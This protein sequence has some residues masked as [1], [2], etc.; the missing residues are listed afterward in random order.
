MNL[1][2][3][4]REPGRDPRFATL[5]QLGSLAVLD[6]QGVILAAN[7]RFGNLLGYSPCELAGRSILDFTY[8]KDRE[9]GEDLLRR[10]AAGEIDAYD[11]ERRYLRKDGSHF[12]ALL[13][14]SMLRDLQTNEPQLF[15][16][17]IQDI[18]AKKRA[19]LAL[20][21][22]ETRWSFALES[23]RQG[24]WD[25]RIA[26]RRTFRSATWKAMLG[27]EPHEI[28]DASDAWLA[29]MHPDDLPRVAELDKEQLA[30]RAKDFECEFRMRHKQGH[31][32][33]I[34]DRAKIVERGADGLPTR[35]IGTH[36]DVSAQ[37]AFEKLLRET[38][39]Q[40]RVLADNSSDMIL[41]VNAAGQRLY[42][43]PACRRLLGWEPNEM[44][45]I[46]SHESI[47][48]EDAAAMP[49]GLKGVLE[50][51]DEFALIHRMRRKDG[52]YVWVEAISRALPVGEGEQPERIVIARNIDE[53][54]AAE[55]RLKNSEARYRLLAECSSDLVFQLDSH[56]FCRYVSPAC[57]EILGYEPVELLGIEPLSID[58]PEDADRVDRT[59][60]SLISGGLER[61][62][63]CSRVRRRDGGWLWVDSELRLL[64]D[65]QTGAPSGIL[66]SLR[67]ASRRKE[68]E[69]R[70]KRENRLLAS[71]AS[72]D[73]LTGL[74]NR[75]AFDEALEREFWRSRREASHLGLIVMDVDNFKAFNDLYGHPAGD[76]CLRSV[77][78]AI[79]G[80]LQRFGDCA[81]RYGGEEFAVLLA[82]TDES[83]AF[84]VAERIRLAVKRL[85]LA[86]SGSQAGCVTVSAG[87]ASIIASGFSSAG[88]LVQRAD[89]ALYAAKRAGRDTVVAA[90]SLASAASDRHPAP[91]AGQAQS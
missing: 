17:M 22:T 16:S 85:A 43:S 77:G 2:S 60:R 4:L 86:H 10:T 29:L 73:S 23:A 91:L 67:D 33:W 63:I 6:L 46:S 52:T 40:Y 59:L 3:W 27:Y 49:G 75:R 50:S 7:E 36:T 87:A 37:K 13:S 61:A 81:A 90:T 21:E 42:A 68:A 74:A 39:E 57:R 41:R 15:A 11:I 44:L 82:N 54:I 69:A 78:A 26:E 20:A 56:L 12:W 58:H 84:D 88:V 47:H 38:G 8:E 83:G 9:L 65:A 48:P 62:S 71:Q 32:V 31:W 72:K 66:G 14:G 89:R 55:Q 19:E 24:V 34:L 51:R 28:S 5:L 1:Q 30:G 79:E 45:A 80:A 35:I 53:R 25:H 76:S 70:L 18:D 64:R